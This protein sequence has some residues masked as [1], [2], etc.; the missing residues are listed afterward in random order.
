MQAIYRKYRPDTFDKVYGQKHITDI[1]KNQIETKNISH[2]YIFSGSRGTGKTSCA[3]IFAR[4]INCLNL[5]DGNP[6]NK[7]ENCMSSLEESTLDIVEMDAA[8]NRRIDDIRELRDKVIYPP[9]KLKYKVY[10]IDE[11]HMITNEGFN[12]L[13]KIMEEPP[14]HLVFILATTEIDKIPQTI[15]SRCQRYEFKMINAKDISDNIKYILNDLNRKMDDDAI[16]LIAN[17]ADGAMRDALSILDQVLSIE[18]ENITKQDINDILGIVD[19]TGI[20]KLVNSIIKK[21]ATEVLDNLYTISHNKPVEN[22]MDE[23]LNHFRNLLLSKNGLDNIRQNN[24]QYNVEYNAQSELITDRQIVESMSII[25]EHQKKLKQADNQKAL[26]EILVM[27]LIDYIDYDDLIARVNTLEDKLKNI[28]Q[29]GIKINSSQKLVEFDEKIDKNIEISQKSSEK[30]EKSDELSNKNDIIKTDEKID[31]TD[32][33]EI[34]ENEDSFVKL[35]EVLRDFDKIPKELAN[36]IKAS[37]DNDKLILKT[38]QLYMYTL[39]PHKKVIEQL[40]KPHYDFK[41][42]DLQIDDEAE[43]KAN[44][45]VKKLQNLFGNNFQIIEK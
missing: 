34:V 26:L 27:R 5:Q 11:A 1:L 24:T 8:S 40:L 39:L 38:N 3:K 10:I 41:V 45:N 36:D 33:D 29:N 4:A 14:K 7:C 20:F 35:R 2:A 9:T 13:L 6:C 16:E 17:K 30:A 42:L 28:E 19:N 44:E 25:I 22:V 12:A 18:K 37:L 43:K 32:E 31:D 15:L 23:L 21:D